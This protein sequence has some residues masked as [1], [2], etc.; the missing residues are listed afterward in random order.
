MIEQSDIVDDLKDLYK[1]ATTERSHYY[2]ASCCKRAI[3][4]LA[5]ERDEREIVE[6]SRDAWKSQVAGLAEA[7]AA[8]RQRREPQPESGQPDEITILRQQLLSAQAAIEKAKKRTWA[9]AEKW[10][11]LESVDIA[12]LHQHD[13]EV[14]EKAERIETRCPA[15]GNNTLTN[16]EGHLLCTWHT[17]PDPAAIER[18]HA[19]V[20]QPLVEALQKIA[21]SDGIGGYDLANIAADA[22][23]KVNK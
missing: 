14:R 10:S 7:L 2:V 17:C 4:A 23:A 15:C 8:E 20:R 11:E 12:A 19:E 13:A 9:M 22:L 1:Q 18:P 5:A 3:A 6:R 16:N 21:E